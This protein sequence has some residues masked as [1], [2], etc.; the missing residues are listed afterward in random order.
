MRKLMCHI[1]C[2]QYSVLARI[3]CRIEMEM[4]WIKYMCTWVE[5]K[6]ESYA[7][8]AIQLAMNVNLNGM[9]KLCVDN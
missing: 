1:F 9:N 8:E 5:S 3:K 6:M 7:S 2:F 4:K